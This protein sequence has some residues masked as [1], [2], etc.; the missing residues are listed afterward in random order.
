MSFYIYKIVQPII[1]KV[2]QLKIY[3]SSNNLLVKL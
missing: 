3:R 1:I 2:N